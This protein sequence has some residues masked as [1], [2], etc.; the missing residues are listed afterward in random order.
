MTDVI[1]TMAASTA[2][3]IISAGAVAQVITESGPPGPPGPAGTVDGAFMIV[4]RLS[5]LDTPQA[6]TTARINL[7]LQAIDCGVFL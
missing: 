7:E 1:V 2:D 3:V 5:E 6:K 4:N